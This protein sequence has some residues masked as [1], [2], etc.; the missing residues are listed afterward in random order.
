MS[1]A[2]FSR[3]LPVRAFSI[4][5][6]LISD[7][8]I[9]TGKRRPFRSDI[10]ATDMAIEKASSPVAQPATQM[11]IVSSGGLPWRIRGEDY[12]LQALERFRIP[13]KARH[14]DQ[15]IPLEALNLIGIVLQPLAVLRQAVDI[16]QG[17]APQDAALDHLLPVQ[18]KVDAGGAVQNVQNTA[19]LLFVGRRQLSPV[20]CALRLQCKGAG[21]FDQFGDNA[22]RWQNEIHATGGHSGLRHSRQTSRWPRPGQT[23]RRRRL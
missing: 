7:A 10:P 15:Q 1:A 12:F 3:Y 2:M 13:E 23:S 18:R 11:R 22:L 14:A 6:R 5:A 19:E 21:Q 16:A 20:A 9:C 4:A 17:E 8:K